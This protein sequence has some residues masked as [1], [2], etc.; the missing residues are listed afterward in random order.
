MLSSVVSSAM[1]PS[2]GLSYQAEPFENTTVASNVAV[3]LNE[4][5]KRLV[6]SGIFSSLSET[7]K[8]E[9]EE[10]KAPE[11]L[12]VSFDKPETLRMYIYFCIVNLVLFI[13]I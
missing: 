2:S 1:A 8:P 5:F 7:K 9:E 6:E 10:K 12:L 11:V 13:N 4:L 3:P